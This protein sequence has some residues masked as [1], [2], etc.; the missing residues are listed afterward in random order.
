[1]T[2]IFNVSYR[3]HVQ[4]GA[5]KKPVMRPV[6][7]PAQAL[8]AEARECRTRALVRQQVGLSVAERLNWS[9]K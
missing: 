2:K 8:Q 4:R 9:A 1:M 6:L 7:S 5:Q 3:P